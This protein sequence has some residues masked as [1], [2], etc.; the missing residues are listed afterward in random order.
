MGVKNTK[1]MMRRENRTT[2]TKT[3]PSATMSATNPTQS[4]LELHLGLRG[5]R[6]E[7]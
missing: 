2:Q 5:E 4:G 1:E 3:C 6:S 7:I